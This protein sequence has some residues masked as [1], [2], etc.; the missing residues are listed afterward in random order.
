MRIL[1]RDLK[2]IIKEELY[3]SGQLRE[4]ISTEIKMGDSGQ[5][6][7]EAQ[8]MLVAALRKIGAR[9]LDL[10]SS[11]RDDLKK[12]SA[13]GSINPANDNLQA[14]VLA[15]AEAIEMSGPDGQ[16]GP[17][18]RLATLIVQALP[19]RV[20]PNVEVL[21]STGMVDSETRAVLANATSPGAVFMGSTREELVFDDASPENLLSELLSSPDASTSAG[22]TVGSSDQSLRRQ[23]ERLGIRTSGKTVIRGKILLTVDEDGMSADVSPEFVGDDGSRYSYVDITGGRLSLVPSRTRGKTDSIIL[24]RSK[25]AGEKSAVPGSYFVDAT[26]TINVSPDGIRTGLTF[27]QSPEV[28]AA[29]N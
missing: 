24:M 14:H 18:S 15:L 10:P 16:F 26:L 17:M 29:T 20:D 6:V 5:A 9:A 21:S 19:Y 23:L 25:S 7:V 12:R 2:K 13:R 8:K 27:D 4:S 11:L 22:Y 28:V 1:G 3:R